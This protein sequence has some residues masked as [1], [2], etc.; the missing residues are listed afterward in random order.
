MNKYQRGQIYAIRSHQTD[1]IYIGSTTQPLHKRFYAHKH[2]SNSCSSKAILQ[3]ADAYI[4]L[5]EDFPCNSKKELEK[6]E[7]GLIRETK[8]VNRSYNGS[9]SLA[10]KIERVSQ[11]KLYD[12]QKIKEKGLDKNIIDMY[13]RMEGEIKLII[14][15]AKPDLSPLSVKTYANACAKVLEFLKSNS[16]PDLFLKH[17]EIEKILNEKYLKPNTKKTKIASVIVLLRCL[18]TEKTKKPIETAL[19]EYGKMIETLTGNIKSGLIDGEKSEKMK[20]NWMNKDEAEKV[21]EHLKSLVPTTGVKTA[22]ELAN[23]RNY[24]LYA[25]YQ[26]IPSRNEFADAKIIFAPTKKEVKEG[27]G[28]SSDEYNFIVLNKKS[29][30]ASYH[31]NCYKTAKT[32]GSKVIEISPALYPLLLAYKSA[33]DKFNGGQHWAFLNNNGESKLT[34][35]R[36]GVLYAGLGAVVGKKLGTTLNRH[37]AISDVV[38]LDA[39]KKLANKMGHSVDEAVNVYA[40]V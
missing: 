16:L 5:I 38:P 2:I 28:H 32:Y 14:E 9:L 24:V 39:M 3:Y 13:K 8:C 30:T 17:K 22:K 23:F 26:D 33:V 31:L 37:Q 10:E 25:L 12:E 29:K 40:K 27:G 36:L 1:L 6:R 18:A 34:R 15:K 7:G 4:E 35:N 11:F 20:T 21:E 19:S